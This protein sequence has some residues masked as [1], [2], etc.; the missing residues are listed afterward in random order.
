M[1]EAA[2]DS[3]RWEK[4]HYSTTWFVVYSYNAAGEFYSG[5]F[6]PQLPWATMYHKSQ[7]KVEDVV[8]MCYPVGA[9]FAL[10]YN[11]EQPEW[12]VPFNRQAMAN[13]LT[14]GT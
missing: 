7:D 14:A 2:V 8:K 5:E 6:N 1:A 9:K 12:S 11:P 3:Y 10:R 4:G 13:P